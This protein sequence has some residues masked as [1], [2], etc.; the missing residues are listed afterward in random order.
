MLNIEPN[1]ITKIN[2][3]TS[4]YTFSYFSENP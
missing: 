1:M 3:R 2:W 4:F